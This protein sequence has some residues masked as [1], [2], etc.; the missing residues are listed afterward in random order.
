MCFRCFHCESEFL[1]LNARER[2]AHVPPTDSDPGFQALEAK[3]SLQHL[4]YGGQRV[5]A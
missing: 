3:E 4:L 2:Y 1:F 5:A